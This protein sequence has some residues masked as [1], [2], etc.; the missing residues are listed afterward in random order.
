MFILD[1]V[2]L[3]QGESGVNKVLEMI[4]NEFSITMALAGKSKLK[5]KVINLNNKL[6]K[7]H[8]SYDR[9]KTWLSKLLKFCK[10]TCE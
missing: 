6:R 4:R 1:F 9:V 7:N 5:T 10:T 8:V 2:S 3:L